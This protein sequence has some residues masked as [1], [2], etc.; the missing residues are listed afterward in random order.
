MLDP[1]EEVDCIFLSPET[2]ERELSSVRV[3]LRSTSSGP[4]LLYVVYTTMYGRSMFGYIST[5]R[6]RIQYVP[7][8]QSRINI[9]R[10]VVGLLTARSESVIWFLHSSRK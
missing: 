6:L 9:V 2:P 3:T 4:A 7:S 10:T 5:G 1:L 8:A